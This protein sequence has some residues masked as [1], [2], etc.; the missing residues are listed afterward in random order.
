MTPF[1]FVAALLYG[2]AAIFGMGAVG[3]SM[4]VATISLSFYVLAVFIIICH[5][6]YIAELLEHTA[7]RTDRTVEE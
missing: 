3:W 7:P 2:G 6:S 5:K 4:L 1:M